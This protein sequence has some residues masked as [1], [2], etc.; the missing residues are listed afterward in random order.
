MK[1]FQE[2]LRDLR[3][4]NDLSQKKL[5][6]ILGMTQQR[7][8]LYETGRMQMPLHHMITLAKHYNVS[9]DYLL[10]LVDEDA[11]NV[12]NVS[13][14]RTCTSNDLIRRVLSLS[15]EGRSRAVD[16]VSLLQLK[17]RER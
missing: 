6:A 16:Y 4:D 5:A 10:G 14:T 12:G 13:L 1:T 15:P 2:R 8:S 17:Y 3:E 11:T 9:M 7:Y